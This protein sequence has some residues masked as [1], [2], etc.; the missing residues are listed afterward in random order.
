VIIIWRAIKIAAES[1]T[2]FGSL[3]ASGIAVMYIFH[4]LVNVGMTLGM[5]PVVGIPLP[6]MSFGGTS[7]LMNLAAIGILQSISMRRKKLIF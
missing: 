3:L 6:L 1:R 7:L 2:A 5:L 4:L